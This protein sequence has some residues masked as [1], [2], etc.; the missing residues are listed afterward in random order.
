MSKKIPLHTVICC[1]LV[2]FMTLCPKMFVTGVYAF[3]GSERQDGEESF[4]ADDLRKYIREYGNDNKEKDSV[5]GDSIQTEKDG[6]KS[7]ELWQQFMNL[8]V[9]EEEEEKSSSSFDKTV[10]GNRAGESVSGNE[11]VSD[12]SSNI[13]NG[14]KYFIPSEEDAWMLILVNKQNPI[15]ADY[16]PKLVNIN[17]G[18]RIRKEVALPLAD[19]FDAAA[20]DGVTLTVCSAYRSHEH[21]QELFDRKIRNYT[22]SGYSYLDAFRIGSYS[23]I[24]PG[25]SEHELGMALDIVTPG[26]TSLTEGFA[27]TK[28]GNWLAYN[29]Y[30]YG[31]ILRY[32][33]GKE[34]ITGITYEPWHFRYVGKEAAKAIYDSG[35][36]LEEYLDK[37]GWG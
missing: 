1:I 5:S 35:L 3:S 22:G 8:T 20:Q 33:K 17:S 29:S 9:Q 14:E 30:K 12:K 28:A 25:T 19:M 4:T 7:E 15:P 11:T 13:K 18:A 26:Y 10:S 24:I 31:F 21:Q 6:M 2:L 37:I 16:D 34:Y 36:T 32:P 23:V 27:D